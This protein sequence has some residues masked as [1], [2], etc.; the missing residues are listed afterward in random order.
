MSK[1]LPVNAFTCPW[2]FSKSAREREDVP[3]SRTLSRFAGE[4]TLNLVVTQCQWDRKI[5]YNLKIWALPMELFCDFDFYKNTVI[6][7]CDKVPDQS[8]KKNLIHK[9]L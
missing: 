7:L 3:V 8:I 2:T 9:T 5:E 4:K 6:C 1:Y